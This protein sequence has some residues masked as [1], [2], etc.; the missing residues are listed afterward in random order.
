MV[1]DSESGETLL[2]WEMPGSSGAV[3]SGR[4]AW[5]PDGNAFYYIDATDESGV[6]LWLREVQGG[7]ARHIA[8]IRPLSDVFVRGMAVHGNRVFLTAETSGS[9]VWVAEFLQRE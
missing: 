3:W 1:V 9:N 6:T 5:R 8:N 2:V 4:F 7:T